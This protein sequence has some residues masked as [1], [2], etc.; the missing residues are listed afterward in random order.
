MGNIKFKSAS[1]MTE[2]NRKE[3]WFVD[4]E[5]WEKKYLIHTK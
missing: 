1:D 4:V 3:T 2:T 5:N